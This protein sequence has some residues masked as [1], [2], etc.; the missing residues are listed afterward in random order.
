[1]VNPFSSASPLWVRVLVWLILASIVAAVF[2]GLLGRVGS[3]ESASAAS[4]CPSYVL[5]SNPVTGG[6][7]VVDRC[8][9]GV[10]ASTES[11]NTITATASSAS[12]GNCRT[13]TR[14]RKAKNDLGW[15]MFWAKLE[16]YWCWK[17]GKVTYHPSTSFTH[18]TTTFGRA[19]GYDDAGTID[20]GTWNAT[21]GSYSHSWGTAKFKQGVP[22]PV[23]GGFL[24]LH[25]YNIRVD[26]YG[27]GG[28]AVS[29]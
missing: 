14:K 4:T 23:I 29:Y 13:A 1:M 25:D 10:L 17:N 24:Q 18:A 22:I 2:F 3:V 26:I 8:A 27:Y 9:D 5:V 19:I 16:K 11:E 21:D 12:Y 7:S 6:T 15:V 28:G 20:K